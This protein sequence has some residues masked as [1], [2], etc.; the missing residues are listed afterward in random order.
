MSAITA[1]YNRLAHGRNAGTIV[2]FALLVI[3]GVVIIGA[4]VLAILSEVSPR[5]N[6]ADVLPLVREPVVPVPRPLAT[7]L[8]QAPTKSPAPPVNEWA[9]SA[10]LSP[11][12]VRT[13]PESEG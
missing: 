3:A 11:V 6:E 1:S 10:I 5:T 8:Q 9:S 12:P 7:D 2:L 13:P 4:A